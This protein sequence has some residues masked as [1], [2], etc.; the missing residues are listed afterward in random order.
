MALAG[1]AVWATLVRR[2]VKGVE[3]AKEAAR[4]RVRSVSQGFKRPPQVRLTQSRSVLGGVSRRQSS[5]ESPHTCALVVPLATLVTT[6]LLPVR[7]LLVD[8]VR[9]AEVMVVLEEQQRTRTKALQA[10][11]LT[12]LQW[13]PQEDLSLRLLVARVAAVTLTLAVAEA[14]A[15]VT[16]LLVMSMRRRAAQ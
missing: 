3:A 16:T 9:L 11:V 1:R 5:T 8:P 14:V 7:R 15:A 6:V 12:R 13:M 2:R 4:A 10:P